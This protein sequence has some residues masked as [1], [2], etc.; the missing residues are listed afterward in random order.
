MSGIIIGEVISKGDGTTQYSMT[1]P[2]AGLAAT[3]I[4][5]VLQRIGST[6]PSLAVTVEHK[7]HDDTLFTN[8]GSFAAIT[9]IGL[10]DLDVTALKEELRFTFT[11]T[12]TQVYEGYRIDM[13][14]PVWRPYA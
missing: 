4:I 10:H 9:S 11:V 8:A 7:N 14:T 12:A 5:N 3:F 6:P 1:F 13:L 2:R